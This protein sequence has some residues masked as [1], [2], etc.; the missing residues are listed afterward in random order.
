MRDYYR[1]T[2]QSR[3]RD[4]LDL[5]PAAQRLYFYAF[6]GPT[7]S[8]WGCVSLHIGQT[9]RDLQLTKAQLAAAVQE[10]GEI[11]VTQV[12][13]DNR[14]IVICDTDLS[15][16]VAP[17]APNNHVS[18]VRAMASIPEGPAKVAWA[19]TL[20]HPVTQLPKTTGNRGATRC[21][22]V[23]NTPP[24][25]SSS[26]SLSSSQELLTLAPRKKAPP[27]VSLADVVRAWRDVAV[28]KGHADVLCRDGKPSA[29][30]QAQWSKLRGASAG[31]G[32][33][34]RAYTVEDWRRG[35]EYLCGCSWVVGDFGE[36]RKLKLAQAFQPSFWSK[37]D[38]QSWQS[39]EKQGAE[40]ATADLLASFGLAGGE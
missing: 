39:S 22:P 25:L 4:L 13:G 24:T 17:K 37:M 29:G 33:A 7:S 10:L 35:F 21:L 6:T 28:P 3:W 26:L 2:M 32:A 36:P 16:A 11:C 38:S 15:A 40:K 20:H 34:S 9:R 19:A 12:V 1:R 14:T 27:G 5:S 18:M 31:V 23:G 8:A 30:L